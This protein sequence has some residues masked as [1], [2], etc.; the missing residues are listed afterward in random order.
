MSPGIVCTICR[1]GLGLS[2]SCLFL[3]LVFLLFSDL[4]FLLC[5]FSSVC[6]FDVKGLDKARQLLLGNY[7]RYLG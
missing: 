1:K 4:L 5:L 2:F 7:H 6:L 3:F